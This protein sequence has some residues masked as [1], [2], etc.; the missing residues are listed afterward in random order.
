MDSQFF[1]FAV[2]GDTHP[3]GLYLASGL[4]RRGYSVCVVPSV[5][6]GELPSQFPWPLR[7]PERIGEKRFDELLFRVGFFRMEESGLS[8]SSYQSQFI[9][10][11][12]R[13][14]FDGG[15]QTWDRELRREFPR[16]SEKL[17]K[18]RDSMRRSAVRSPH[19]AMSQLGQLLREDQNLRHWI[20]M[21]G[22]QGRHPFHQNSKSL[23]K[24]LERWLWSLAWP[25]T[26]FY[27]IQPKLGQGFEEFLLEHAK[28][29]GA[30]VVGEPVQIE[31]RFRHF[32]LNP[33][34]KA[35][36]LIVNTL[37]ALRL[38]AKNYP[39]RFSHKI[40]HWLYFDRL[41]CNL[42]DIPEPLE[43]HCLFHLSETDEFP[44]VLHCS[45]NK[46]RDKAQLTLGVWLPFNETGAWISKLEQGR[47]SLKRLLAF[48]P[49]E[50]FPKLP[51]ILELTEMKGECVR[52]GEIERL[53]LE[54]IP[55]SKLQLL[56]DRAG[57]WFKKARRLPKLASRV[58]LSMPYVKFHQDR[59]SSLQSCYYL[60]EHF[61]KRRAKLGASRLW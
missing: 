38:L 48:L 58:Y 37:G 34:L 30:Q 6:L 1:D 20:I 8:P 18:I 12:N 32:E 29:W 45:R 54:D 24:S 17:V 31:S 56:R 47:L 25:E 35:K 50:V 4:A 2:L 3:E 59:Q 39:D 10:K 14:A 61:E 21:E 53:L 11:K 15:A 57:T 46:F 28:K 13:L 42:E 22:G 19:N 55:S 26:K 44:Y 49:D 41:T 7:L 16:H 9:L 51:S 5:H 43:E 33:K 52:R 40:T 27:R 60:L 36:A 23:K